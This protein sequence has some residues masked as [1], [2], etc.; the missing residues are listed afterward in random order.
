MFQ[1]LCLPFLSVFQNFIHGEGVTDLLLRFFNRVGNEEL[2]LNTAVWVP[3]LSIFFFYRFDI[4]DVL[5]CVNQ[6]LFGERSLLSL[7]TE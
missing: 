6:R 1:Y 5:S 4:I 7:F 2:L 3:L